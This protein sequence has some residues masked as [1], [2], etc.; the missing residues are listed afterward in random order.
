MKGVVHLF[1]CVNYRNEAQFEYKIEKY[2][3]KE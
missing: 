2:K 1:L 3:G